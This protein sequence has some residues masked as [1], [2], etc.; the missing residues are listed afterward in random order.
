MNAPLSMSDKLFKP[1]TKA[2]AKL[3]AALFGPSGGGKTF[4][5]LAIASGLGG[6]VALIDSE[7]GSA[8]KY[9]D[10]FTFDVLN[11]A[12]PRIENYTAAIAA[13]GEAGYEVLICDSLSHPWQELLDEIDR[14]TVSSRH[15]GNKWS[16]WSEGT[17]KQKSLINAILSYPGHVLATMRS[18]TEWSVESGN[19]GKSKPV[20]LGLAP[21]QGKGIEYEFDLLLEISQAHAAEVIKDRTGRFQDQTLERPGAEF[22]RTLAA[23]L[24]EGEESPP[25]AE[26]PTGAQRSASRAAAP[27]AAPNGAPQPE[28]HSEA[29]TQPAAGEAPQLISEAQ[30]RHIEARI[31]ELRLD[32]ER[33]KRWA[34]AAF[35]IENFPELTL[36]QYQRLDERLEVFAERAA[37]EAEGQ[38]APA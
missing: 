24:A 6:R 33:V 9:A 36:A 21:E 28:R 10:R 14:I 17:P 25:A 2:R 22:G 37:I 27:S 20:R 15:K 18:K 38:G 31:N 3:R 11:L 4:S 13:A 5:A 19:G 1:A 34:V 32:R 8:S 29:P 7:H 23:W 26:I 35:G 30:H 12:D 16:A